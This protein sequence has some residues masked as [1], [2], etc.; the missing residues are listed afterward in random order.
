MRQH[1]FLAL[2]ASTGIANLADGITLFLLPVAALGIG[3]SPAGVAAVTVVATLAWP[4]LGLPAGWVADRIDRGRL[5]VVANILRALVL[6]CASAAAATDSLLLPVLLLVA[7]ASGTIEAVVDSALTALVPTTVPPED[8]TRANARIETTIN[9]T[10]QLLGAPLAGLLVAIS[11]TASFGA[12]AALYAAA[13]GAASALVLGG[14]ATREPTTAA[15]APAILIDAR[16]RAGMVFLWRQP[17]LRQVTFLTAAMNLV[18]GAFGAVF[19]IYALTPAGLD[20]SPAAYGLLLTAAAVGGLVSSAS[21][22]P[23]RRRWGARN[24]LVVDC[25]GTVLL[26]GPA[27]LGLGLWP[28]A[29][30]VVVAGAGSSIWRV[31]VATIRQAVTPDALLG[32]VYSASRVISWGTVPLGAAAAGLLGEVAT[33]RTAL[34]AATILAVAVVGWFLLSMRV[35]DLDAAF[36]PAALADPADQRTT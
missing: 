34:G 8:R 35:H 1:R 27:A 29:L 32:R 9:L 6:A 4:V 19:V 7:A 11:L 33:V 36:I 25:L 5:L 14:R 28:V 31:L 16:V 30:G 13:A 3:A 21:V 23:L 26:V 2:W 10:N 24:L 22:D 20:L 12:G 17:L 18:W 15:A